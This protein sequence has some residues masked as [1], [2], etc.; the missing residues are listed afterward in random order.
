M[1]THA[2][3]VVRAPDHDRAGAVL[4][5]QD[6]MGKTPG[7]PLEIGEH[8]I[9][10]FLVQTGKRGGKEMIIGHRAKTLFGLCFG[11]HDWLCQDRHKSV[12]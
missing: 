7:D 9:A 8:A 12:A 3:I 1:L 5:M 4:G 2:E 11:Q 10:P 6:R